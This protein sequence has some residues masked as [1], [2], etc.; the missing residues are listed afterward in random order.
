M[1]SRSTVWRN[2]VGASARLD[3]GVVAVIVAVREPPSIS[4]ISPKYD[5]APSVAT[6]VPST[7]TFTVP[8][9]EHEE[10]ASDVALADDGACPAGTIPHEPFAGP[11]ATRGPTSR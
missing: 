2:A 10:V 8:F 1:G 6:S 5:P 9:R 4:A 3:T 7:D 11:R